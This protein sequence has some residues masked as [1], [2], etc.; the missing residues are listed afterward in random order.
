MVA[1]GKQD[2]E[3]IY[4]PKHQPPSPDR[5]RS[6]AGAVYDIPYPIVAVRPTEGTALTGW[7]EIDQHPL[8][9]IAAR[10]LK[11][12]CHNCHKRKPDR[13]FVTECRFPLGLSFFCA[14]CRHKLK[15]VTWRDQPRLSTGSILET[16]KVRLSV[17][18]RRGAEMDESKKAGMGEGEELDK[19]SPLY[20]TSAEFVTWLS[21]GGVETHKMVKRMVT[22]IE[23]VASR[24]AQE[25]VAAML[26]EQVPAEAEPENPAK[27]SK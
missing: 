5:R 24:V 26:A 18:R 22:I 12:Y 20:K 10:C 11:R 27:V 8:V 14:S 19:E 16:T 21:S 2:N 25:K 3:Y 17:N 23:E 7:E 9:M 6:I 4:I 15:R 13:E 1:R